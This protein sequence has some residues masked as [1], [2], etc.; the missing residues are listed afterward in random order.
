MKGQSECILGNYKIFLSGVSRGRAN[1]GVG[2]LIHKDLEQSVVG[3]RFVNERMMW[4][5]IRLSGAV[6]RFV[7]VYS[8]REEESYE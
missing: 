2:F 3:H 1:W 4:V 7:S 8:F 5:S 6:H